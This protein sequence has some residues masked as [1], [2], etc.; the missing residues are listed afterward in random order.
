M[1][2]SVWLRRTGQRVA[3]L[4]ACALLLSAQGDVVV[5]RVGSQQLTLAEVE[6]RLAALP[7][8]Q[9]RALADTE[10][11][12]AR[13]LVD[14]VLVPELLWSEQ[15][16]REA[17]D[18][19]P[20][21]RARLNAVLEDALIEQLRQEVIDQNPVSSEQVKAY[22][23]EHQGD[24]RTPTRIRIWRIVVSNDKLARDVISVAAAAEGTQKW[25]ELARKHSLDKATSMRKGDLGFVG[26]DGKTD[27]PRVQ[28]DRSLYDAA[29]RV[30]DGDLV[31]D[32]VPEG[33]RFAVVWR[34]G[35]RQATSRSIEDVR[36][37]IEATLLRTHF[38]KALGRLLDGLKRRYVKDLDTTPLAELGAIPVREARHLPRS[39]LSAHA[40]RRDPSPRPTDRGLR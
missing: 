13:W 24:F 2:A 21:A 18:K 27:V 20:R 12:V 3:A 10:P 9:R 30:R 28:V 23:D 5:A 31:L 29:R 4:A 14:R 7:G 15:A 34:R 17:L 36:S 22:Y 39:V 6:S 19:T 40:A 1:A 38:E 25:S 16:R 32:P 26:P 35:T 8:F 37:W 11:D 33:N